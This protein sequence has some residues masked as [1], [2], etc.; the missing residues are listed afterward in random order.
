MALSWSSSAVVTDSA[1]AQVLQSI[2]IVRA[3]KDAAGNCYNR[4]SRLALRNLTRSFRKLVKFVPST[5]FQAI[6]IAR[7]NGQGGAEKSLGRVVTDWQARC[8]SLW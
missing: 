1:I 8:C 6:T 3:A 7:W 5:H 4:Y 2:L